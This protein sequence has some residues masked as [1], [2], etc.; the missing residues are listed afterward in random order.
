M[1]TTALG[2]R[3]RPTAASWREQKKEPTEAATGSEDSQSEAVS[4]Q[5]RTLTLLRRTGVGAVGVAGFWS[6]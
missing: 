6:P 3:L 5:P 2:P 1:R 4:G